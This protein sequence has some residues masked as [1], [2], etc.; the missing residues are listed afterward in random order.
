MECLILGLAN[1]LP[2]ECEEL[3]RQRIYFYLSIIASAVSGMGIGQAGFNLAVD[4][5]ENIRRVSK[6]PGHST[7][8]NGSKKKNARTE[9]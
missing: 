3:C 6:E 7:Y 9:N 8:Q 5:R 4:S 1:L 2:I